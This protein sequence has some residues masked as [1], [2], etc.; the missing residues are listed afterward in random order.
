MH[1]L[2]ERMKSMLE[3]L[4]A[5]KEEVT[6]IL[7]S[8]L[9]NLET[10]RKIRIPLEIKDPDLK[11]HMERSIPYNFYEWMLKSTSERQEWI[12]NVLH[13]YFKDE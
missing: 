6:G 1:F 11:I 3:E 13:E 12:S 9:F 4:H 5:I 10:G 8:K 7:K 2:L